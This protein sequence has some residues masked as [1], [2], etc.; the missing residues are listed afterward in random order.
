MAIIIMLR[1]RILEFFNWYVLVS[2]SFFRFGIVK[3]KVDTK[4]KYWPNLDF[5]V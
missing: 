2:V 1:I 4:G 3:L 5:N